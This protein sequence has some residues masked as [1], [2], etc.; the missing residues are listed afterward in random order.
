MMGIDW[1]RSYTVLSSRLHDYVP[2]TGEISLFP[3]RRCLFFF[4]V[5]LL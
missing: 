1:G 5:N 4:L 3:Y 2:N